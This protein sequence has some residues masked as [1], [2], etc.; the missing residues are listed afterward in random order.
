MS[1]TMNVDEYLKTIKA[2]EK[3][4]VLDL[5]LRVAAT[6]MSNYVELQEE[7]NVFFILTSG[8]YGK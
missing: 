7:K 5:V 6:Q 4:A 1:P 8:N 2:N 3:A